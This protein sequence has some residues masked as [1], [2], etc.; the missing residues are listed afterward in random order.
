[1]GGWFLVLDT[2]DSAAEIINSVAQVVIIIESI[3]I[4]KLRVRQFPPKFKAK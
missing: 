2:G 1:M 4:V 3:S